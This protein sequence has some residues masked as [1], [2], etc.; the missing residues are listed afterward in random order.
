MFDK[1]GTKGFSK[2][3]LLSAKSNECESFTRASDSE[4]SFQLF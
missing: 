2:L 1:S 4:I 3:D